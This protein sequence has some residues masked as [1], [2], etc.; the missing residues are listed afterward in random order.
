MWFGECQTLGISLELL[1]P[2]RNQTRV[3]LS[4]FANSGRCSWIA[5]RKLGW[6]CASSTEMQMPIRQMQHRQI[7]LPRWMRVRDGIEIQGSSRVPAS[8]KL[9]RTLA[10]MDLV[11]A[12]KLNGDTSTAAT[13]T[14][15]CTCAGSK[16]KAPPPRPLTWRCSMTSTGTTWSWMSS[17]ECLTWV[18]VRHSRGQR[19]TGLGSSR[20]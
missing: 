6:R 5:G 14:T 12:L 16:R 17:I 15:T 4:R 1:Q 11:V 10:A 8:S 18:R 2:G 13:V 19:C 7:P 20:D 3:P 9:L